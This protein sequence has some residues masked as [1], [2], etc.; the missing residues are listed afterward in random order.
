MT[1][2]NSKRVVD[3][4][5]PDG[6]KDSEDTIIIPGADHDPA[7]SDGSDGSADQADYHTIPDDV[8]K[9]PTY[10]M[11]TFVTEGPPIPNA[12]NLSVTLD[13]VPFYVD[14]CEKAD[15]PRDTPAHAL[16][17]YAMQLGYAL[18]SPDVANAQI[19]SGDATGGQS[20]FNPK[21]MFH[22]ICMLYNVKP[23]SA[24]R[25]WDD[26]DKMLNY[27]GLSP[28]PHDVTYRHVAGI[29]GDKLDRFVMHMLESGSPQ[30]KS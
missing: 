10:R 9:E 22:S 6:S 25:Y 4:L 11:G 3:K 14:F 1:T 5:A 24:V 19:A 15:F 18:E 28:I 26:V 7:I 23:E 12:E 13:N 16:M 30:K 29:S 27:L 20:N 17:T 2:D 8:L 21:G